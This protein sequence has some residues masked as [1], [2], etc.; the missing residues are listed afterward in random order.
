MSVSTSSVRVALRVRPLTPGENQQQAKDIIKYIP[1]QPQ[2]LVD[3]DR[4][5]TFDYIYP[6]DTCQ[7]IVFDSAVQPLVTKFL[8]GYNATI[9]AY[10]QTG[11]GKTYTMGTAVASDSLAL[12]QQ[13]GIVPRFIR[14][15]FRQLET[16]YAASADYQVAASFLEL[17]NEDLVDLLASSKK[18]I[19]IREDA[20]GQII[21][22]GVCEC[23]VDHPQQLFD[24]LQQG[25]VARTT[26]ST[27]MNHSSS[28][29]HA[30]FSV[31]LKQTLSTSPLDSAHPKPSTII[32]KFHFVDLAGSERLKRTNAVG[33]RAKEGISI[34][35]GLLALGNVISALG[36]E[37]KR[38]TM[39]VPYRDSKLTRLLQDSL[40]GNSQTLMVACASPADL[41]LAETLSTLNYA[42][43]AR[44]IRNR[45]MINHDLDET[46]RLKWTISKLK[47]EQRTNDQYARALNDEM[48]ALKRTVQQLQRSNA[49]LSRALAKRQQ[50][51]TTS[52]ST[53]TVSSPDD[54]HPPPLPWTPL[55]WKTTP[56]LL[57]LP[58]SWK[59]GKRNAPVDL[60]A[61]ASPGRAGSDPAPASGRS[62]ASRRLLP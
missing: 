36:D 20:D 33:E 43:R 62:M 30:I 54:I 24:Y 57:L 7:S 46:D 52:N 6:P 12:D 8:E 42:N 16:K 14:S 53:S 59:A 29:S 51:T 49:Q 31:I 4:S 58:P 5:F 1:D 50:Q 15:L 40:G 21:W 45:V 25:S 32:S 19:S 18:E 27:D 44:N 3:T 22:N 23:P 60:A 10:G 26:A 11:S 9:L 41:N 56:C 28:R 13:N 61:C 17:Y 38:R 37:N 48:D 47:E 39:H 2:I 34:N 35:A 55:A